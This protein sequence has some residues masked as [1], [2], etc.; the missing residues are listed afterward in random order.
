MADELKAKNAIWITSGLAIVAATIAAIMEYG[1]ATRL[2]RQKFEYGLIEKALVS[3]EGLFLA[4]GESS[5]QEATRRL[6]FLINIGAIKVLDKDALRQAAENPADLP[7]FEGGRFSPVSTQTTFRCQEDLNG[8]PV[9]TALTLSNGSGTTDGRAI[10]LIKFVS[11]TE[12]RNT[13]C[14]LVA[15]RFQKAYNEDKLKFLTTGRFN[16]EAVLCAASESSQE[17]DIILL[18]FPSDEAARQS[19]S[20]LVGLSSGNVSI[21]PQEM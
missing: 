16:N 10:Q 7:T 17:C 1:S 14:D 11:G 15:S 3:N 12:T 21:T 19:L 2:E 20:A 5:R 6:E 8:V 18:T 13:R 4:K 9:L